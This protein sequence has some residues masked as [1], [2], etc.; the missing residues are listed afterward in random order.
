MVETALQKLVDA[1][2]LAGAATRAW[3]DGKA[4]IAC[5]GWGEIETNLPIEQDTM[6][7]IASMTKPITSV[8]ALMFVDE[9]RIALTD[10]IDRIRDSHIYRPAATTDLMISARSAGEL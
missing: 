6:F 1:G 4:Q 9:G 3:R 7:R 10:S 2:L 8:A 5:V